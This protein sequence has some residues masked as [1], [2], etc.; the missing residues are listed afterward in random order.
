MW[1]SRKIGFCKK[2][3]KTG[4]MKEIQIIPCM[5]TSYSA[6]AKKNLWLN[7]ISNTANL[8]PLNWGFFIAQEKGAF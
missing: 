3:Q 8:K 5:T 1:T 4:M 6:T 2:S 7:N